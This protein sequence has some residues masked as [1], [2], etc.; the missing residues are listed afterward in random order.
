MTINHLNLVVTDVP[1]AIALFETNF[2]FTCEEIKGDNAIAILINI[3]GFTLVLMH[4]KDPYPRH[5]HFGFFVAAEAEVDSMHSRLATH[6]A[7]IPDNPSRI[8]DTYGFYFHFDNL[9]IEVGYRLPS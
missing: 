4:G 1:K 8:R 9:L 3:A 5:F 2:D 6:L 7:T